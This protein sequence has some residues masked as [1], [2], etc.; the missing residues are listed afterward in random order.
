LQGG[1]IT[2]L[3]PLLIVGTRANG[4]SRASRARPP[5]TGPGT[6]LGELGIGSGLEPGWPG[7]GDGQLDG[8]LEFIGGLDPLALCTARSGDVGQ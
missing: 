3:A 7:L 6:V 2:I 5:H 4:R 1:G 8:A